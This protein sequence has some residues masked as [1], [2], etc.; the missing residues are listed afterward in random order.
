MVG[1]EEVCNDDDD[2]G[3]G[4]VDDDGGNG[5]DD[6]GNINIVGYLIVEIY[7]HKISAVRIMLNE[8]S[9]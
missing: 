2:G 6:M 1:T 5:N 9:F 7:L 8:Q 4:N 3:G